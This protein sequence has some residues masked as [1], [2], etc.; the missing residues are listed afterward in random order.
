MRKVNLTVLALTAIYLLAAPLMLGQGGNPPA[1]TKESGATSGKG[2]TAVEQAGQ[3]APARRYINLPNR[4]VQAPFSD[5]VL[6]GD[7]LYIAGRIG[8]D[9]K[10]GKPPE[11][12]EQEIKILL[13]GI[14]SVLQEAGMTMDDLV[15]VQVF[16]PDVSLYDKFNTAYRSYFG[17]DYP[18]RAFVGSGPLLRGGHFEMLGI[19]VKR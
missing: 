13:D 1:S 16:C 12:L 10:T 2:M 3:T 17:K 18:A 4:P 7:T 19:A 5:G 15:S 14:R 11:D 6:I 9:P 8:F